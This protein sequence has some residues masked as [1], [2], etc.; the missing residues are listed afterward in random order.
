MSTVLLAGTNYSRKPI[1]NV[2]GYDRDTLCIECVVLH[3]AWEG[4]L[5]EALEAAPYC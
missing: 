4:Q 2:L 1:R 5:H 3:I